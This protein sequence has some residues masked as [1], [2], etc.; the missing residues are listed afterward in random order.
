[1]KYK[2]IAHLIGPTAP[3]VFIAAVIFAAI[4]MLFTLLVGSLDRDPE[5]KNSPVKFS[6]SYLLIDNVK[7]IMVSALA[8]LISIR[9]APE[10][11]G[12]EITMWHGLGFGLCYDILAHVIK[13][14]TGI[15]DRKK[16]ANK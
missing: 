2:V 13:Q 10:L 16:P 11:F 5:S 15:L 8:V 7:R 14:N 1:M 3:D 6:F 9:F 12:I 4:G